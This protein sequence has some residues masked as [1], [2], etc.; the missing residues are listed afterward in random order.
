MSNEYDLISVME[1]HY[2]ITQS[3][4]QYEA[5]YSEGQDEGE[6]EAEYSEEGREEEA[7]YSKGQDDTTNLP[8]MNPSKMTLYTIPQGTVLY[9]A[10]E[11]ETF[12]P[13]HL[14]LGNDQLVAYFTPNRDFALDYIKN[15]AEYPY[16]GGFVHVFKT[17]ED[18]DNIR[19]IDSYDL[20]SSFNAKEI[21]NKY[22]SRSHNPLLE[23]IGFFFPKNGKVYNDISKMF[24]SE[25]SLCNPNSKKLSYM[26]SYRCISKR[27][28][29]SEPYNFVNGRSL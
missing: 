19:I 27:K 5:E 21:E 4:G 7:E 13:F 16:K 20:T 23:G 14:Q 6:D 22:C 29:N 18:I 9:H 15:C 10:S 11:K 17:N 12:N 26:G 28:L 3:G 2:D 25:F 1:G 8:Y 24:D